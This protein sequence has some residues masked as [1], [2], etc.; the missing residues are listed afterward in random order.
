MFSLSIALETHLQ[1][2]LFRYCE[3]DAALGS[4]RPSKVHK[5]RCKELKEPAYTIEEAER[6]AGLGRGRWLYEILI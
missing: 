4:H 5:W 3:T 6:A 2:L 1:S